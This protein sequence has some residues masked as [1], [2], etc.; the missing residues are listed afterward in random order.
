MFAREI[1]Q[2]YPNEGLAPED[3]ATVKPFNPD[4]PVVSASTDVGDISWV[5]PT[6][7]MR[8]ATWVPGTAPHSWQ[9]VAAGGTNIGRKGMLVAAKS[10]SLAAMDLFNDGS[11]VEQAKAE[12][13]KRR[14]EDFQYEC[15]LGDREP[16]L[17]YRASYR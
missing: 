4:P 9:A 10:L 1:M 12:L 13:M 3:A 17:D 16:P 5:V 15:L 14:G 2:T 6:T 7:S 11:I 8:A